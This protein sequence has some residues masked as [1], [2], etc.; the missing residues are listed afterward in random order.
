MGAGMSRR[1]AFTD[2]ECRDLAAWYAQLQSLGTVFDKCRE[3][4]VTYGTLRDAILRGQGKDVGHVRRKLK[5]WEIEQMA[6]R[7]STEVPRESE[8]SSQINSQSAEV[9]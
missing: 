3:H 6:T 4:G 1:R 9:A 2:E 8:T 5:A 7:L